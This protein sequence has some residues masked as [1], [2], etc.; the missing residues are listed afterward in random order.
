[1][2]FD[3]VLDGLEELRG[4]FGPLGSVV[5]QDRPAQL[6][7]VDRAMAPEELSRGRKQVVDLIRQLFLPSQT[8]CGVR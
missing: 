6:V 1:M 8:V 2:V 5:L 4:W 3:T 7:D